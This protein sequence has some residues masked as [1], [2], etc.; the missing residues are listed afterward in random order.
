MPGDRGY[1]SQKLNSI[2]RGYYSGLYGSNIGVR[3]GILGV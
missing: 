2:K 1:M 3:R